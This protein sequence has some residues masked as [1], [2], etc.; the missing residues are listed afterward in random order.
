[1]STIADQIRKALEKRDG[2]SEEVMAPLASAYAEEVNRVNE[3]LGEAVG[4]LR[5]GLRSEAIQRASLEPNA[6]DDAANLDFPEVGEWLEILQFLLITVPPEVDQDA[7][8]QINEAIVETQPLNELLNRHRRLAIA[9]APL[10]WRLKVLRRIAQVDPMNSVWEEDIEAWEDVR[11]KQVPVELKRAISEGDAK[12]VAALRN[13]LTTQSWRVEPSTRLVKQARD[14]ADQYTYDAHAERLRQIAPQLHDAFGQY[15]ELLARALR[16]QWRQVQVEL[17]SPAPMELQEQVAPAFTWL[18]ELDRDAALAQERTASVAGLER[19]LDRNQT[20]GNLQRAYQQAS[21]FDEPIPIELEQRFRVTVAEHELRAKRKTQAILVSIVAATLLTAGLIGYWQWN[22]NETQRVAAATLQMQSL[23]DSGKLTEANQFWE[24]IEATQPKVAGSAEMAS[25]S[26]QLSGELAQEESRAAQF[27]DYLVQ[28]GNPDPAEIDIASL[29]KAESLAVSEKEKASVFEIQRK[30]TQWERELQAEHT[31]LALDQLDDYRRELDQIESGT[32]SLENTKAI[33]I[34]VDKVG[35]LPAMFPR[36]SATT[37]A[38]IDLLKSRA[39][40]IRDAMRKQSLG[41]QTRKTAITRLLESS[42]LAVFAD[43][44]NAFAREVP[45][46]PMTKEFRKVSQERTLWEQVRETN[47]FMQLIRLSIVGRIS[48]RE[49]KSILEASTK[50][51]SVV[52]RN[53]ILDAMPNITSK[54]EK[55]QNRE[56][57]LEKVFNDLALQTVAELVTIEAPN[58]E[59]P[60]TENRYFIYYSHFDQFRDRFKMEGRIGVDV[61]VNESAAVKNQGFVGPI[62]V[63]P[64][65]RA[66]VRWLINKKNDNREKLLSDWNGMFLQTAAE[67]RK[68]PNLDGLVKEILL[69]QLLKGGA[70]GSDLLK[71]SLADAIRMLDRRQERRKRWFV[72]KP[73]ES[74]L[75][76][77]IERLVVPDMSRAYAKRDDDWRNIQ[78]ASVREYRWVG[79]L[80]RH[81]VGSIMT[82]INQPPTD[83]TGKLYV[84]RASD[85]D[86]GKVEFSEVGTWVDDHTVLGASQRDLVAGRPLFFLPTLA[87]H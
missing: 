35:K 31:D 5:K 26:S 49:A 78:A 18:D 64:E 77:S 86:S 61:V 38:Q 39:I 40:A 19:A 44:L 50:L 87:S 1:M 76:P 33:T 17:S 15:N 11:L 28:A 4:L 54:L 42:S 59:D 29:G 70:E 30:R 58:D 7:A 74:S 2:V 51:T 68:R 85:A 25:L 37:N 13:E 60:S 63:I 83:P 81:D 55:V 36:R 43:N 21:R 79:C 48:P 34:L 53:P 6:I 65:P 62:E 80:L 52:V 71:Q 46:S 23:L 75:D 20:V 27:A 14:A 32:A 16:D 12:L 8:Q 82:Q 47:K 66:T 69:L 57:V 24:Q 84:V 56:I 10:P 67:L 9:K 41:M 72:A 3:R 22:A 73:L 45:D